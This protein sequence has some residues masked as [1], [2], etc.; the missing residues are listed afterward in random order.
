MMSWFFS[1]TVSNEV[2]QGK[3]FQFVSRLRFLRS[4]FHSWPGIFRARGSRRRG[5]KESANSKQ[6]KSAAAEEE[7]ER[8]W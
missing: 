1:R 7:G 2:S 8:G 5:G 6:Q 3:L 4:H